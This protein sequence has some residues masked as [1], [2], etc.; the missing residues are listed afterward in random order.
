[1]E[2]KN[3]VHGP[4]PETAQLWNK[5]FENH[6]PFDVAGQKSIY[7]TILCGY[8]GYHALVVTN[9]S[10]NTRLRQRYWEYLTQALRKPCQID[11]S[12]AEIRFPEQKLVLNIHNLLYTTTHHD[13]VIGDHGELVWEYYKSGLMLR[14]SIGV[15]TYGQDLE[16]YD[17]A[18]RELG[19]ASLAE[20]PEY[21]GG[22]WLLT[23]PVGNQM[24]CIKLLRSVL[25][26]WTR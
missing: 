5:F 13:E 24:R 10:S 18:L 26:T 19:G 17:R 20:Y 12:K 16:A 4:D 8:D 11:V 1:M 14:K 21:R 25:D 9:Q 23:F 3:F 7:F 15:S 6:Q 22:N 2:S